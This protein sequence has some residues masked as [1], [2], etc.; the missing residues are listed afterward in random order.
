[1]TTTTKPRK[2]ATARAVEEVTSQAATQQAS[3]AADQP[4]GQDDT[5]AEEAAHLQRLQQTA[6]EEEPTG[7]PHLVDTA[8]EPT[9]T[10][11][12]E[13]ELAALTKVAVA[14]LGPMFPSLREVYTPENIEAAASVAAPLCRKHGWLQNGIG[15]KY[16]EEI[17]AAAVLAP[18]AYATV[19]GVQ[20]DM[21]EAQR[22]KAGTT[23]DAPL[24]DLSAPVPEAPA[25]PKTVT[26]GAPVPV[27]AAA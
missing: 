19:K 8:A 24:P 25:S 27:E 3:D 13:A 17:A 23:A 15:G 22:R 14:M 21:A 16:A 12:L 4:A 6:A 7:G 9:P 11:N 2:T 5:A 1:M 18:L 10:V 20:K 26:F